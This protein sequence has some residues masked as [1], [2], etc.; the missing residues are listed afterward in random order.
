MPRNPSNLIDMDYR[1]EA[2]RFARLSHGIIDAHAH[3]NGARASVLLREAMDLYGIDR[4]WSMTALEQVP[5]VRD[6]MGD[7]LQLIA[8]PDF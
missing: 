4:I 8:V 2:R 5:A 1:Q 7:R 3:V 6:V